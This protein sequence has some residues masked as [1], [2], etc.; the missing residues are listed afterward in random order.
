[1]ELSRVALEKEA[2]A[3][4]TSLSGADLQRHM[5][6]SAQALSC[7]VLKANYLSRMN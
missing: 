7:T 6:R 5:R 2:A 4:K 3:K 1:L